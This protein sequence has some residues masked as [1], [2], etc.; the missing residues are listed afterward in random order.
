MQSTRTKVTTSIINHQISTSR[1]LS[2]TLLFITIILFGYSKIAFAEGKKLVAITEIVEHPSLEQAK[3]GIIDVL[4]ENG[5]ELG[6][7]LEIV[8][9]N[10]Q[11]A[12]TNALLIAKQFVSLSPDAIVAISTPSAQAAI[13]AMGGTDIPLIFSSVT[14]PVAAGLVVK[15]NLPEA[16][17]TGA[18]DYPLID[19]EIE[20]IQKLLPDAKTI[21]FLYSAGEANSVN[22]IDLMKKAVKGKLE[23]IDSQVANSNQIGQAITALIGRVDVIYIPSDNT[24]F[25]AL[26]KLIQISRKYKLPVFSSDPDSVKQGVLACIG[27]TQYEV[28]RTAGQLLVRVLAGERNI[29]IQKPKIAQIFINQDSAD[30]MGIE[31]SEELLGI[32]TNIVV[33]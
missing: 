11:G 33:K 10:A 31:A 15:I 27:Y 14:D 28:G 2:F 1:L 6:H 3:Q 13:K 20:L 18:I 8:H 29:V 30:I 17:I 26:P 16:N 4:Q 12:I 5:Y 9:K 21:G 25:S 23:Y 32:K 24:V 22:T 7:N 19:E